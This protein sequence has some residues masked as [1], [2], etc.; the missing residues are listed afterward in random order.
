[1]HSPFEELNFK[2]WLKELLKSN[3]WFDSQTLKLEEKL[4]KIPPIGT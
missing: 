2:L 1:L 3:W 4:I